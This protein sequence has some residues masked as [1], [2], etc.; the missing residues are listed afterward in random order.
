MVQDMSR[1]IKI[2]LK[3][4]I[5]ENNVEQQIHQIQRITGRNSRTEYCGWTYEKNEDLLQPR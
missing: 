1:Q 3:K 4:Q 2:S 5:L